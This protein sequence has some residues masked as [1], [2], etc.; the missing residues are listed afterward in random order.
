VMMDRNHPLTRQA[1][2]LGIS[3][4]SVYYL[5]RPVSEADLGLM[6]RLDELHLEHPFAGSMPRDPLR[7]EG[8]V[9]GALAQLK[10]AALAPA[11]CLPEP[12]LDHQLSQALQRERK[13][14]HLGQLLVRQSGTKNRRT[15]R[16]LAPAPARA[17]HRQD[18]CCSAAPAAA[19]PVPAPPKPGS[20]APGA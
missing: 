4:G 2:A 12:R 13:R 14:V 9:V 16:A 6:R 17:P 10:H 20:A 18:D 5:P 7:Q 3:R 8:T 11:L 19:R 15:A 1:R